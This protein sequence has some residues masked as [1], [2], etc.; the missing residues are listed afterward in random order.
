MVLSVE[1]GCDCVIE[2]SGLAS[3]LWS[4]VRFPVL[5]GKVVVLG[6]ESQGCSVALVI[7]VSVPK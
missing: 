7:S 1:C 5:P 6:Q 3:E 4:C 2:I